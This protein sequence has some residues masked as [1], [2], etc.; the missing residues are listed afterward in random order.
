[1]NA[2]FNSHRRGIN[3]PEKHGTCKILSQH[4]NK[5]ICKGS[6]FEVQ[7]I[8]KLEGS[9]RTERG[10]IDVKIC[11]TRRKREDFWMKTLRTVYPY[12]LN[13]RMGDDCV[14][15]Q[16]SERIGSKFPTL[17]R[18]FK[19]GS[20][21]EK[22]IGDKTLNHERFLERLD[23]ILSNDVKEA[24]NFIRMSLC[25]MRKVDL[26]RLG[27]K[28]SDLLLS[29]PLDFPF[30]QWYSAALD[31]IDCRLY[32]PPPAKKTRLPLSN[33]LHLQF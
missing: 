20:R 16:I 1:M 14:R 10:A 11:R 7:I 13:D 19:R 8:E 25:T 22:R 17:K 5:G 12:G 32:V 2:R 24:L 33:V 4:F 31:I 23:A 3:Q 9:G 18:S 21:R 28:I 26:K 6:S 15:D 30:S 27:D 29:R